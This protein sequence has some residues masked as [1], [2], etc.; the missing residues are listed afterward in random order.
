MRQHVVQNLIAKAYANEMLKILNSVPNITYQNMTSTEKLY[1]YRN[2]LMEVVN[3]QDVEDIV[4]YLLDSLGFHDKSR[5]DFTLQK[6][7]ELLHT[8]TFW[9]I[10]EQYAQTP[11]INPIVLH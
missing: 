8:K 11:W 10:I 3:E 9:K 5:L 7:R 1:Y 6:R 2:I 4:L